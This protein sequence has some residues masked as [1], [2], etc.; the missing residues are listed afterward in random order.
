MLNDNSKRAYVI[1]SNLH[2][3]MENEHNLC[4]VEAGVEEIAIA[5]FRSCP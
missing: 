2:K 5:S 4:S 1:E 3:A